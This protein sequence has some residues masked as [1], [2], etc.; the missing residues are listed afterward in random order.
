[1]WFVAKTASVY[2]LPGVCAVSL[3]ANS[4]TKLELAASSATLFT[5]VVSVSCPLVAVEADD[6]E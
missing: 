6:A 1:M 2:C 4:K 5:N 3:R